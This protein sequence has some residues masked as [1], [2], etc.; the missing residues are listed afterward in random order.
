M[1]LKEQGWAGIVLDRVDGQYRGI[2]SEPGWTGGLPPR[3]AIVQSCDG[4]WIGSYLKDSVAPFVN[5]GIEYPTTFSE[6]ARQSM[7]DVGLGWTPQRCRFILGDGGRKDFDLPLRLVSNKPGE[8]SEAAI[9]EVKKRFVATAKPVGIYRTGRDKLWLGMSNFDGRISGDAYEAMYKQLMNE[10]RA[11]W[12]V[13]DLRGNGGGDSSWG[14]R[15]LQAFY[16]KAYG[17][18]LDDMGVYIKEL[19]ANE[20]TIELYRHY[21]SLPEFAASRSGIEKDLHVIEAAHREGRTMAQVDGMTLERALAEAA[22]ARVLPH[23]PNGSNGPRIAAVI[24][25]GCFSSCMNLSSRSAQSEIR[26]SCAS[27]RLAIHPTVKSTA[28]ICPAATGRSM[29][30]PLS[31]PR[32]RRRVN[33][34]FPTSPTA[35][36]WPTTRP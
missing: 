27:R 13:L 36:I 25:R 20:P 18:L 35:A 9:A 8:I 31:T 34:S 16:G 30:R 32:S 26:S 4:E 28:S 24:D 17:D 3:G 10:K 14:N 12:A 23:G 5:H 6:L 7:F 22:Q 1:H 2:W 33:P 11:K 29:F 15:A 19:T 21:A